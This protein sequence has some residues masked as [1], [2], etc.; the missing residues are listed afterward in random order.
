[1]KKLLIL[2]FLLVVNPYCGF[3]QISFFKIFT[4]NGY[5]YGEGV[6]Q[7]EDSSY[8]VCGSSSSFLEAPSQAFLMK[9]D[10]AGNFLWSRHYGGVEAES[11]RRVLY[12]KDFG[13]FVAGYTTSMGEGAY[14]FYLV[15]TDEDGLFE[16]EKTYG[17]SEW[18]KVNAAALTR[19]TGTLLVG[20]SNSTLNGSNDIYFVRTDKFGD[21]LWTKKFGGDGE[22]RANSI[23]QL[24]DS[25][26]VVAGEIYVNDSSMVKAFI[27]S[28]S[29]DG[30]INWIDTLG[31]NGSYGINDIDIYSGKINFV[32]WYFN[33][34]IEEKNIFFGRINTSGT[35]DYE[36]IQ[37]FNFPR[38]LDLISNYGIEGKNYIAYRY[39]DETSF[40]DGFD[41]SIG[42]FSQD[43]FWDNSFVQVN[44]PFED[45]GGQLIP[46]SDKGALVVGYTSYFGEGGANVFVL[47]IGPNDL[48]PTTTGVPTPNPIVWL[49][50]ESND[51]LL[52]VYPNPAT[53]HITVKCD[54]NDLLIVELS[55]LNGR[56]LYS[57]NFTNEIEI[58]TIGFTKGMYILKLISD[59]KEIKSLKKIIL[60]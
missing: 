4:N 38:N 48:Y 9:L 51:N 2:F 28:I 34:I 59:N 15:K 30:I 43:L 29:D 60:H 57:N 16:W 31:D 39:K 37:T 56:V 10:S 50:E 32:G 11:A 25:T 12:K 26:F 42:R 58:N 19:D 23:R 49:E 18:E 47:K 14:D 44:N 24:N 53:D 7:L 3:G 46:T 40:P 33:E 13:F 35:Y 22:D 20:E 1:M 54:I 52:K 45:F 55:D 21:T 36:Y 17:G 5:D 8:V 41:L 6:V 27:M